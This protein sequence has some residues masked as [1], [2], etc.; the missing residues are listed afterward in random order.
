MPRA[1][2]Q[3]TV[4]PLTAE[5][6]LKLIETGQKKT[7]QIAE[8]EGWDHRTVKKAINAAQSKRESRE[9]RANFC[10]WAIEEHHKDLIGFAKE[11]YEQLEKSNN[12]SPDKKES[13]FWGALKQHMPKSFLW[14][15]IDGMEQV[16]ADV[17]A[18]ANEPKMRERIMSIINERTKGQKGLELYGISESILRTFGWPN[19]DV[20]E[21]RLSSFDCEPDK[22]V[23]RHRDTR[24]SEQMDKEG[25]AKIQEEVVAIFQEAEKLFESYNLRNLWQKQIKYKEKAREELQTIILRRIISG[26]CRYC[27]E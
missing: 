5:V 13:P 25:A 8:D 27:P 22:F 16:E 14:K 23:V 18:V 6:W 24:C 4:P 15:A 26:Q 7:K 19:V 9:G 21:I 17:A 11:L 1:K 2:G 20:S 12:V 10:R 3:S